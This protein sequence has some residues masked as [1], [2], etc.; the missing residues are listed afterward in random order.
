MFKPLLPALLILSTVSSILLSAEG[1][2]LLRADQLPSNSVS[3]IPDG[4]NFQ[5]IIA[6]ALKASLTA[7]K[8][9]ECN[10]ID[11]G[12]PIGRN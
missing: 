8:G 3:N 1:E 5:K 7:R 2:Y 9:Y 12:E 6:A 11:F 4:I 10:E